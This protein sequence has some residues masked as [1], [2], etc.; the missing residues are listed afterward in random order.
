MK[1]MVTGSF[2]KKQHICYVEEESE[3]NEAGIN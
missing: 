3:A 1:A 2:E